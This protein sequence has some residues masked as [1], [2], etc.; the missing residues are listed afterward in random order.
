MCGLRQEEIRTRSQHPQDYFGIPHFMPSPEDPA[1]VLRLNAL[2]AQVREAELTA[3][4]AFGREREDLLRALNRLS[5]LLYVLM[6]QIKGGSH[7]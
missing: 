7:P 3:A 1:S 5:S 2:R 4:A 6:L